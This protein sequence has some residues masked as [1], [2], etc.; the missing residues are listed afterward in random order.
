[1]FS[2]FRR[3]LIRIWYSRI[4]RN[5][6]KCARKLGVRIGERCRILDE[7]GSVF[8]TEP[9]LITVGDHVVMAN[10]V[11]FITHEA[12]VF[13]VRELDPNFKDADLFRPTT[14][15]SN[16]ILGARAVIMPGIHIGNNV[17]VG[18]HAVVTKDI[19][20][21]TI[22]AGVPAKPISTMD[23]Y[24]KKIKESNETVNTFH[25]TQEQKRKYLKKIHPEWF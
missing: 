4:L 20:D 23:A 5:N 7:P 22:A 17:I 10:G 21:N 16:V 12:G 24:V 18:A 1:M 2:N 15:G 14:V 25:M 3:S 19:P 9:W 11:R 13:C 8:G 6:V